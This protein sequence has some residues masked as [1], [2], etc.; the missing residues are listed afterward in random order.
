[1]TPRPEFRIETSPGET[2]RTIA[3]AGELDS[4]TAVAL[5]AELEQALAAPGVNGLVLDLQ[6]VSFI[7]SAG[8][9]A[10]IQLEQATRE[11]GLGLTVLPAPAD[12]TRLLTTTGIGAR[13]AL[14]PQ[15]GQPPTREFI[16]RIEL[17]LPDDP[18]APGQA[19]MEVRQAFRQRCSADDIA[20]ALLLTSELV[21]NAVVHP[22]QALPNQIGLRIIAFNDGLR[23]EVSDGGPGF[24]P[25]APA[26][27]QPDR[28]GR[29]LM[30]VDRL[31]SRWGTS[32]A[33]EPE[34]PFCVWFELE[35]GARPQSV[36][37]AG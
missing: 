35:T 25:A 20:T 27:R 37:S 30:L 23:V 28:G 4:A 24:D 31:A 10:I 19:R 6:R 33:E 1:V 21:T 36:A 2:S 32:A 7:D 11:R 29:G 26:P 16:E 34:R 22:P 14:G 3:V 17:H 9:R 15:V 8:L 18:T 5:L 12:V 13:L